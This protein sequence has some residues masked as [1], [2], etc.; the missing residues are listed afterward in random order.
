MKEILKKIIT[1]IL[2]GP[3]KGTLETDRWLQIVT[4]N[5]ASL[6]GA[7]Y[8]TVFF[9]QLL[10]AELIPL[11]QAAIA[12]ACAFIFVAS[13][14]ASHTES[15]MRRFDIIKIAIT[16]TIV[17]FY[18]MIYAVVPHGDKWALLVPLIV[19]FLMKL[20]WGVIISAVYFCFMLASDIMFNLHDLAIFNRYAAIYWAQ[21]A[22]IIGYEVLR[23]H[24]NNRLLENTKKI[25]FLSVTDHLTGLYNRR[26]F[27][28][29]MEGEYARAI[30][31]KTSLSFLMIDVDNFKKF[32]DTF[33][34]LKGDNL[35]ITISDILKKV[36]MRSS[37]LAFRMGGEEFGVLL[38]D[39]DAKGALSVAERIRAEISETTVVTVSVGYA[40]MV[41]HIGGNSEGLLKIADNNLYKAKEQGRN[42]VIGG[43]L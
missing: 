33:G 43:I 4:L 10:L 20:K 38:P 42:R 15:G 11:Y 39:T 7:V 6:L 30:R 2:L 36:V 34:H 12:Y 23:I 27:S 14:I 21:V 1:Q 3:A 24:N 37:D 18:T 25:E 19:I 17:L 41:P 40:S 16:L 32:N 13:F 31:Q 5:I 9:T 26:Y 35:L 22:L 28:R 8:S 29:V